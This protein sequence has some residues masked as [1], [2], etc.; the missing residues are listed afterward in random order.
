LRHFSG[1]SVGYR[2]ESLITFYHLPWTFSIASSSTSSLRMRFTLVAARYQKDRMG[3]PVDGWIEG[4]GLPQSV[5]R[6]K[7]LVGGLV[8]LGILAASLWSAA[9][10]T[11]YEGVVRIFL[12]A[13]EVAAGDT[14]RTVISDAQFIESP[15]VLDRVIA[16]TGNRL[17]RKE[18]DKQLTVE[19]SSSADFI[20]ISARDA[21][22]TNAAELAD[23]VDLAYRQIL[24]EQRQAAANQTIAALEDE[25]NRLVSEIVQIQKQRKTADSPT[26]DAAEQAK[27]RQMEAIANKIEETSAATAFPTPALHDK[28]AVPDEPVQ[29][30][31]L[32]AGAIGAVVGLVIGVAL[33]WLL[34]ARRRVR[35]DEVTAESQAHVEDQ[36]AGPVDVITHDLVPSHISKSSERVGQLADVHDN[37]LAQ[38]VGRA[39]NSLDKDPD[40]LYSLAE[41]LESQHQNFPQITAERLRDRLLLDR[42]AV[43]LKTDGGLDLAG[44]VGWHPDGVTP[45]VGHHDPSLLR[46]LGANGARQ[47]ESAERDELRNAGL[48]GDEDQT[49]VVAPLKHENVAFGVLLVGQEGPDSAASL[50]NGNFD[51]I[52]SFA[53]SV[54]PDLHAWLLLHKLREQ[55]PFYGKTKE[56]MTSSAGSAQ[57]PPPEQVSAE[58]EQ[59][60]AEQLS[61]EPAQQPAEPA[62]AESEPPPPEQPPAEQLSTEPAQQ[63]AEPASAESAPPPPEQP[64]AEQLSTEPAQQPAEP[65]SARAAQSPSEESASAESEQLSHWPV[66]LAVSEPPSAESEPP[67]APDRRP[68]SSVDHQDERHVA[69]N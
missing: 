31:P 23:A 19:P 7:W 61:T 64:P 65:V 6:Y 4:P 11:R 10:P 21:T 42:V 33:A 54:A 3:Y 16:L 52:G 50:R 5:W 14:A 67:T 24:T 40:L 49:L 20:T 51:A 8:V 30:K 25:Q 35:R 45:P 22:P 39:V 2:L 58:P 47:I 60:P 48:L 15:T 29:P 28:A 66:Y 59:P 41:W 12:T 53:R 32:L 43:L 37:R 62:S 63:P 1:S 9:Q 27:R 46:K 34:A 26:L 69:R 68:A 38:R 18:L 56:R 13:E 57:Q 36:P 55:L 17:T 44:S